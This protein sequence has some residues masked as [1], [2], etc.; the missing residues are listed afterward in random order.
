MSPHRT[1]PEKSKSKT[2]RSWIVVVAVVVVAILVIAVVASML[3]QPAPSTAG[4]RTKG[5]PKAS[6]A[7]VEYSDF[8]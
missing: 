5:D 4:T 2:N 1:V 8:Q 3:T 7:I 6:I